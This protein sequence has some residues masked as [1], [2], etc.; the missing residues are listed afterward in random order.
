MKL[1]IPILILTLQA[2]K[3][4]AQTNKGDSIAIVFNNIKSSTD[5]NHIIA[6]FD[7]LS[8]SPEE[9]L[10]K[11]EV[12]NEINK[13]KTKVDETDYCD[14]VNVYFTNLVTLN[15]SATNEKAINIGRKWLAENENIQSK[16]GRY[17]SL[18]ILRGMRMPFRNLGKLNESLVYYNTM[19]KKYLAAKD[20]A[21]VSFVYNVLSGSYFRIGLIEKCRYYQLKSIAF[22]DDSQLDYGT[23]LSASLLGI[24]GKVNRY[25]VLG[26]YYLNENKPDI[27]EIYLKEAM[28]YYHQLKSPL[29]MDD[30]PFLFLQLARCK[31]LQRSDSANF[32]FNEALNRLKEYKKQPLE[33]AFFYQAKTGNY[34]NNGLLDS[35][36][37]TIKKVE[38]LKDSVNI[39]ISS[40]MGELIPAYYHA[41]IFLKQGHAKDGI[42]ILQ[43]ELKELQQLNFTKQTVKHLYLLADLYAADKNLAKAYKI[44][45]KAIAIQEK[46]MQDENEA[47]SLSF[48]TEQK[49]NENEKAILLLDAQ[50]KNNERIKYY[51]LGIVSLLGLLATGLAFFYSN[52]RKT[53]RQLSLKNEKLALTLEQLKSTQAQLIQSEKMASLGELTA[54]IAHEIQNPLNFVNNFS[55]VNK[56]LL[57]ELKEEAS[58][59]NFNEVKTIAD[60]VIN[61]EEKINHHGKRADAIV[62]GMLQHSRTSTG[63]KELTDIN[64]LCDE[65]L[66]LSYHG[67]RAKDKSFNAKF[68]TEFDPSLPKI[69]VVPQ[70]MG[71]VILNLINNAFYAVNERK[72]LN[73]EGFQPTVIVST[74]KLNE[75]IEIK[76]SDNGTG[77]PKNIVDKIFQPFFTTKPTG[78]GTGL[79]LS[80]A[81]DIITKGHGGE[82]SVRT[83][84]EKVE[85]KE[86]EGSTFSILLPITNA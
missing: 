32:Y 31:T 4:K 86:G 10:L 53:N 25:A 44:Q 26:N 39:P 76:V 23:V 22:L 47:R 75:K 14:I 48:E 41:T 49:M 7:W 71:R 27:A 64:A 51:L 78:S 40:Y 56:E 57:E 61:N 70:E 68:E 38:Q 79:G 81:Y 80:L 8:K 58:K 59:G 15:T 19:E 2:A 69:N 77:I 21:A 83:P 3:G 16:H 36:L 9:I 5:T 72:K 65:Y 1:L 50:N 12:M 28:N 6:V 74:K 54:G 85:T 13:L 17:T 52:K 73:E 67:L 43:N 29:L 63:Q 62:K 18:D 11:D 45:G 82:L 84:S 24:S 34:I 60:D 42:N 66:R 55:D 30:V 46:I 33:Y 20:S 35:A 37:S